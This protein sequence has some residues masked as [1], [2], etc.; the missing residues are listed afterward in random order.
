[1]KLH[2]P[3]KSIKQFGKKPKKRRR[4]KHE[5]LLHRSEIET[6]SKWEELD[7][8]TDLNFWI[9]VERWKAATVLRVESQLNTSSRDLR[10]RERKE[11]EGGSRRIWIGLKGEDKNAQ[12]CSFQGTQPI[13]VCRLFCPLTIMT[14]LPLYYWTLLPSAF[15]QGQT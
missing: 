1:M 4:S 7:E 11:E 12:V 13:H 15:F 2:D 5:N 6:E 10:C 3:T 9:E 8:G 14:K